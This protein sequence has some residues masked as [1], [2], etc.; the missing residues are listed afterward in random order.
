MS[1]VE[2]TSE[3]KR[4]KIVAEFRVLNQRV[5]QLRSQLLDLSGEVTEHERVLK[6]LEEADDDRVTYRLIGE[7][8]ISV[9]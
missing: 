2:M 5:Q 4:G 1:E 6:V 3:E 9:S 7:V 8:S